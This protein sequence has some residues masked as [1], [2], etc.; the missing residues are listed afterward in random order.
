M[1]NLSMVQALA[2][3]SELE[4]AFHGD[5]SY[6]GDTAEIYA[7]RLMPHDPLGLSYI[8][9]SRNAV[10]REIFEG[11]A[12]E[13]ARDLLRNAAQSLRALIL[14][15]EAT[16]SRTRVLVNAGDAGMIP[17]AEWLATNFFTHR[18]HV[19]VVQEA[20]G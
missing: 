2:L 19:Q 5:N 15:F 14:H 10:G 16:H 8:D 3:W 17:A 9:R 11:L 13:S 20:T 7:Y 6:S 1:H 12:G 18:I 4:S